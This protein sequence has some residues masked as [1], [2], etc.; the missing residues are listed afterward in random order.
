MPMIDFTYP[1][2]ALDPEALA[3]AVDKLTAALLRHEGAP[4][5]ERVRAIAWAFVHEVPA[6]ALF[7]GGRS[8][9]LSYYRVQLSVPQ[10]TL[11]H[12]PGPFAVQARKNLI[13]E[14]AEIVLEAEGSPYTDENAARIWCF[15]NEVQ[16][17]F[18]GGLG[19]VFRIEDIA[20]FVND[21]LPATPLSE[22]ARQVLAEH[23]AGRPAVSETA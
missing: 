6:G 1:E 2:G 3:T 5:N 23:E 4:D 17:G 14:V 12:G 21:D 20:G 18:W 9:E 19:T 8:A 10:G 16:E 11:L 7:A 13:R 15:I 22:R